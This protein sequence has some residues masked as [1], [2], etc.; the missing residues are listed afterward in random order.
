MKIEDMRL[1][2]ICAADFGATPEGV[3]L[4]N[5][6]GLEPRLPPPAETSVTQFLLQR[7]MKM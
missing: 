6:F 2:K 3:A 7:I 5:K 1:R 4:P